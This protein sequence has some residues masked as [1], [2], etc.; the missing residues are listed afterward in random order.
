MLNKVWEMKLKLYQVLAEQC[1]SSTYVYHHTILD[2]KH[3]YPRSQSTGTRKKRMKRGLMHMSLSNIAKALF[4]RVGENLFIRFSCMTLSDPI[5]IDL[6]YTKI[7]NHV[8]RH[9]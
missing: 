2:I 6:K 4:L 7:K 9:S 8:D 3:V 5:I 1:L